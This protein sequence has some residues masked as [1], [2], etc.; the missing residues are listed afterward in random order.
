MRRIRISGLAVHAT[1]LVLSLICLVPFFLV[2]S[3]SFASQ[4][5]IEQWGYTVIPHEVSV[6][7]YQYILHNP[8]QIMDSYATTITVTV[9]GTAIGM[10]CM[11]SFAYAISHENYR[12]K[13]VLSVYI[14]ITILFNGGMVSNYIWI[15]RYLKLLDNLWALILPIAVSAW[16]IFILRVSFKGIPKEIYESARMDG[17]SELRTFVQIALPLAKTGLATVSLLLIFNLWNDWFL[18]MMYM[19]SGNYV[20]LQYYL[21]KVLND[22]EFTKANM[23]QSGGLVNVSDLPSEGVRMAICVLVAG[24]MLCVFP[25]FQKYF[26]GG[27]TVGGVK[28]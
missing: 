10:G 14:Y 3:S 9:L 21:T 26:V 20:T 18:S 6:S 12:W 2:L 15:A 5:G 22:I 7:S 27:I 17:A 25:F 8:R 11:A 4:S 16:N 19:D 28:G 24:P 13:G 1:M 23:A